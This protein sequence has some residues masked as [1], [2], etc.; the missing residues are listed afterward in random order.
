MS[1]TYKLSWCMEGKG[2]LSFRI[3]T[4]AGRTSEVLISKSKTK[5]RNEINYVEVEQLIAVF[6]YPKIFKKGKTPCIIFSSK[7][8]WNVS[9][10]CIRNCSMGYIYG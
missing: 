1:P 4:G 5:I 8:I 7:I 6:L 3:R 10:V 2:L 9:E